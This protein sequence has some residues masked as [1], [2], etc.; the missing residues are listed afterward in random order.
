MYHYLRG[1]QV[2]NLEDELR[3]TDIELQKHKEKA[4]ALEA[5][6]AS[7]SSKIKQVILSL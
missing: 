1:L 2:T 3:K 4:S 7:H 5:Q 6:S